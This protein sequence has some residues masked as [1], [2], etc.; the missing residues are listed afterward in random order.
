MPIHLDFLILGL[1]I[2]SYENVQTS[3]PSEERIQSSAVYTVLD[4]Y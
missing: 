3:Q 2:V 4:E 1:C